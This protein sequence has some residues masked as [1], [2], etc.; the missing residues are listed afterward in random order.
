MFSNIYKV[1]H[2]Q[3]VVR[4]ES[5]FLVRVFCPGSKVHNVREC[6]HFLL[7]KFILLLDIIEYLNIHEVRYFYTKSNTCCVQ[8]NLMDAGVLNSIESYGGNQRIVWE[9]TT[10][11][12]VTVIKDFFL[13]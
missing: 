9:S 8:V 1:Y 12:T 3:V 6:F 10:V 11:N 7:A 5:V 4:Y 2:Y 13:V